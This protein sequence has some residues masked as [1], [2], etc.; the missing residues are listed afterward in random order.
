MFFLYCCT[1]WSTRSMQLKANIVPE[2]TLVPGVITHPTVR[3]LLKP[4][5]DQMY[6]E[7]GRGLY[8]SATF[9]KRLEPVPL[10]FRKSSASNILGKNAVHALSPMLEPQLLP[11]RPTELC[12]EDLQ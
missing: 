9:D 1:N 6:L 8:C 2:G 5:L 7:Q 4:F 12:H 10:S 3:V 11:E